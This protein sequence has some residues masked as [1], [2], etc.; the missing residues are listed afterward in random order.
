MKLVM[1]PVNMQ[2]HGAAGDD[3]ELITRIKSA[4]TQSSSGLQ[5]LW[6]HKQRARCFLHDWSKSVRSIPLLTLF[7]LFGYFTALYQL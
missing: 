1:C 6:R 2:R 7:F 3:R 5:S 4:V